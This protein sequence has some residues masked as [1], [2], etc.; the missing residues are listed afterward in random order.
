MQHGRS[1]LLIYKRTF[2]NVMTA[3]KD[4]DII[5]ICSLMRLL[6]KNCDLVSLFDK[7]I[8]GEIQQETAPLTQLQQTHPAHTDRGSQTHSGLPSHR[9]KDKLWDENGRKQRTRLSD[10]AALSTPSCRYFSLLVSSLDLYPKMCVLEDCT[11]MSYFF[12]L[13]P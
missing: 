2:W 9:S 13:Y 6:L 8:I 4:K 5:K 1:D 12:H 7:F 11:P 3:L 10:S